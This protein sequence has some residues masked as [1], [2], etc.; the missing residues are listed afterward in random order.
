MVKPV[1]PIGMARGKV[2]RGKAE[3]KRDVPSPSRGS[4]DFLSSLGEKQRQDSRGNAAEK[5]EFPLPLEEVPTL[6]GRGRGR[7]MPLL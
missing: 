6:Q 5:R 1:E 2:S 4:A 7:G 3:G